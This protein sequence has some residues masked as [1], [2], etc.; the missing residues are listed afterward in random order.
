MEQ[1]IQIG[2]ILKLNIY[3]APIDG[4]SISDTDF[5]VTA[6]TPHRLSQI[7]AVKDNL[8]KVDD[9]NYILVV[10]TSLIG[11]GQLKIRVEADIEDYEVEGGYRKE[12]AVVD[13]GIY[14]I[15]G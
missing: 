4:V 14:V 9:D 15:L 12:V 5:K 11:T 6:Y 7:V 13:T 3:I 2:T 10:D 1:E 8:I